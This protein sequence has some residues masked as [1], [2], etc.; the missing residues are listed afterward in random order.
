MKENTNKSGIYMWKNIINYKQYIGSA[1]DLSDR[2]SFYL[3][4]NNHH[5]QCLDLVYWVL[6]YLLL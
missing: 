5:S 3:Y 4:E 1:I 2:L 6:T